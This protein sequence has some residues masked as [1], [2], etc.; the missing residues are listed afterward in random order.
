MIFND[1]IAR[2]AFTS[3]YI[4]APSTGAIA[5]G[6]AAS[7]SARRGRKLRQLFAFAERVSR[8]GP[9][10]VTLI[11]HRLFKYA[12]SSRSRY[13]YTPFKP[14]GALFNIIPR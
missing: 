1:R 14:A 4:S 13:I 9:D 12:S 3:D 7:A 2:P 6:V 11:L 8:T 5:H 10:I